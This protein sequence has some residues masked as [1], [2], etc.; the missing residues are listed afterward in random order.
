MSSS[1]SHPP[2]PDSAHVFGRPL[3]QEQIIGQVHCPR[4]NHLLPYRLSDL[5]KRIACSQCRQKTIRVGD[6]LLDDA[7]Q[8]VHLQNASEFLVLMPAKKHCLRQLL[9]PTVM[10]AV[11]VI[12]AFVGG[13][14][15]RQNS[16][17]TQPSWFDLDQV[18]TRGGIVTDAT[19][20]PSQRLQL[21]LEPPD[22]TLESIGA[23][24]DWDDL[25]KALVQ[26]QVWQQLLRDFGAPEADPRLIRLT[27]L[28]DQL[29]EQFR[30]RPTPPPAYLV[31]FRQLLN[32]IRQALLDQDLAAVRAAMARA[33][34]LYQEHP[35]ELAVYSRSYL[36]IR[37]RFRQL[38][39]VQEGR[40]QIVQHLADAD[41]HLQR[42]QPLEAAELIAEAMFLALRTPLDEEE[43]QQRNQQVARL[44]RELRLVR[45]RRAVDEAGQ[46]HEAGDLANRDR[47]LRVAQD[48]LPDLPN[49]RVEE[50]LVHA[51][52]LARESIDHPVESELG[53]EIA[54]RTAYEEA[55]SHFG[56]RDALLELADA[57]VHADQLLSQS[58]SSSPAQAERISRLILEALD[59]EIGDLLSLPS[60]SPAV[61][62]GLAQVRSA[63]ERADHWRESSRWR[64]VDAALNAK[65]HEVAVQT[66]ATAQE[67]AQAGNLNLALRTIEPALILGSPHAQRV[68]TELK[69]EWQATI[70]HQLQMAAEEA[71]YTEI[72]ELWQNKRYL[73]AW[74]QIHQFFEQFPDSRRQL[75]LEIIQ[76]VVQEEISRLL[77]QL[78]FLYAEEQWGEYRA[79]AVRLANLPLTDQHRSH[80]PKI[81][82]ILGDFEDRA[83]RLFAGLRPYRHMTSD[84]DVV[85]LLES[86]PTVLQLNPEHE[87]A[88]EM[89][90]E[91]QKR[92][93]RLAE[94]FLFEARAAQQHNVRR[95]RE[96]LERVIRLEPDG[97]R[98]REAQR[99]LDGLLSEDSASRR[100]L[101]P[102]ARVWVGRT[103]GCRRELV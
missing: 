87:E 74:E 25:R 61:P 85:P 40:Q 66:I 102:T 55:L 9:R 75:N 91:A 84:K 56:R 63:L 67:A 38:E 64:M 72:R 47:Q 86:L 28:I 26:A 78:E 36:V 12:G 30:P 65:A 14:V 57:C 31:E 68:A 37:D 77:E 103:S 53:Y 19:E 17:E 94:H 16:F 24:L 43:F 99:L 93:E 51:R 70:Q 41:Q 6:S 59:A 88:Q 7:P 101:R 15:T 4:C 92:A 45:G 5:G 42:N 39:L 22:I 8:R 44:Q 1:S 10:L 35:E 69:Q 46:L 18:A 60:H 79:K 90:A 11:I 71:A 73:D 21:D 2:G 32:A 34:Q 29:S 95:H 48:L 13:A 97:P 80:L 33:E 98:G 76:P 83:A 82:S 27:E 20:D 49:D 58:S 62:P 100:W 52:E 89:Y 50:L 3:P 23:L 81:A 54:R 96:Y